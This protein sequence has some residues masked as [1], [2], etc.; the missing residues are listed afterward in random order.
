MELIRILKERSRA[1]CS[2]RKMLRRYGINDDAEITQP[3]AEMQPGKAMRIAV[4]WLTVNAKN[5]YEIE[6]LMPVPEEQMVYVIGLSSRCRSIYVRYVHAA[7]GL[8]GKMLHQQDLQVN[9]QTLTLEEIQSSVY[10]A[11]AANL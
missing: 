10:C 1:N 6:L 8:I 5:G 9:Y 7:P 2:M 11:E 3:L 4:N